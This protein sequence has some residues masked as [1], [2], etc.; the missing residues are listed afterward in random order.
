MKWIGYDRRVVCFEFQIFLFMIILSIMIFELFEIKDGRVVWII[1][2]RMVQGVGMFI[3]VFNDVL[4]SIQ[5]YNWFWVN[6]QKY[7]NGCMSLF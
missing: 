1:S 5:E 7:F 3:S 6:F 4:L 2:R